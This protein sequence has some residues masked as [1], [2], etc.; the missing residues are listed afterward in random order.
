MHTHTY[1]KYLYAGINSR[2]QIFL[3]LKIKTMSLSICPFVFKTGNELQDLDLTGKYSTTDLY[4]LDLLFYFTFLDR[5]SLN[6]MD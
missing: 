2:K 4:I 6:C 1:T 5:V 3:D